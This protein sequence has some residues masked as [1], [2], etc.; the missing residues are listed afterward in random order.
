MAARE[1][2]Q[3]AVLVL[4]QINVLGCALVG[5][6]SA[7]NKMRGPIVRISPQD[8]EGVIQKSPSRKKRQ[9]GRRTKNRTD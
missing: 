2:V 8:Y 5:N 1:E 4:Q 9:S 6:L 3:V 7:Q